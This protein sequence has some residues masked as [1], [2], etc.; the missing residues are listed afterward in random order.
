MSVALA[1]AEPAGARETAPTP[2]RRGPTP[3]PNLRLP[4]A[5][6]ALLLTLLLVP[7]VPVSAQAARPWTAS[8]RQSA[9]LF[10]DGRAP[11]L[12]SEATVERRL[13]AGARAGGARAGGALAVGGG[14][15]ER[16]DRAA[17]FGVLDGYAGL[18]PR[19]YGNVR[20]WL[21][22]GAETVA[23]RDVLAELYGGLPGGVEL[24]AGARRIDFAGGGATLLL[25]SATLFRPAGR[26]RAR[27][28][29]APTDSATALSAGLV[30]RLDLGRGG[31]THVALRGGRSQEVV[32]GPDETVALRTAWDL[33][34]DGAVRLGRRATLGAGLG[35]V[36][37]GGLSR[38]A[39]EGRLR[40]DL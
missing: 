17:A 33:G 37:D 29:A 26:L 18:A 23:R 38:T 30:A 4:L 8:A 13:A 40:L 12:V 31:D 20:L 14:R 32:A 39:V 7:A 19:L 15:A 2:H 21:A 34:L 22:P 28:S 10:D 24:S 5:M 3:T 36:W 35:R 1:G 6:R 25:G 16:Y 9:E 27:V 11:W